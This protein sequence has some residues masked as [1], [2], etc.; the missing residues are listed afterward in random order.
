[1]QRRAT[2][3]GVGRTDTC[4]LCEAVKVTLDSKP[5]RYSKR[6]DVGHT[7]TT[8][9]DRAHVPKSVIQTING[10]SDG[11]GV[12]ARTYVARG[13]LLECKRALDGV[14]YPPLDLAPYVSERFAAYLAQVAT[15]AAHG[16]RLAA[17]GKSVV[18]RKGRRP[19]FASKT[20]QL[21]MGEG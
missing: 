16:D 11:Q 2:E 13:S 15:Q 4:R 18:S 6:G 14:K 1:V 19:K 10:H 9:C 5:T 12:D 21:L 8:R 17:E 3:E 7:L 20:H